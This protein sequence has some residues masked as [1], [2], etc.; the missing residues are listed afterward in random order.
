MAVASAFAHVNSFKSL[1]DRVVRD[2]PHDGG[3][4]KGPEASNYNAEHGW[5]A[6]I[7]TKSSVRMQLENEGREHDCG[8]AFKSTR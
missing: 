3:G 7:R 8:E 4:C 1:W 5:H 2:L 6:T